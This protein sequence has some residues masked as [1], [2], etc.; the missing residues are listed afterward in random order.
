VGV[1]RVQR[2]C[3]AK[4]QGGHDQTMATEVFIALSIRLADTS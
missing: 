4:R 2:L 1:M 3:A